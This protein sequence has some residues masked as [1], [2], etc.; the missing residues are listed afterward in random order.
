MVQVL[1]SWFLFQHREDVLVEGAI[2]GPVRGGGEEVRLWDVE[3]PDFHEFTE[4]WTRTGLRPGVQRVSVERHRM[5]QRLFAVWRRVMVVAVR[6]VGGLLDAADGLPSDLKS[7]SPAWL[8]FDLGVDPGVD[9]A[10]GVGSHGVP[11]IPVPQT[12]SHTAGER[13]KYRR[14]DKQQQQQQQTD[15]C[16]FCRIPAG[17]IHCASNRWRRA[18]GG[19]PSCSR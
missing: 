5:W 14:S 1:G 19:E 2:H 15:A 17:V 18:P 7:P 11:Q 12:C 8:T 9:L 6:L 16:C 4:N 13:L 10:L 3:G